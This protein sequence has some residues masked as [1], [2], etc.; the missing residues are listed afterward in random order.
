MFYTLQPF[1]SHTRVT[2]I[3]I[4]APPDWI[5]RLEQQ[6][7]KRQL[8]D[9]VRVVAGGERRQD[10]VSN[11]LQATDSANEI[12]LIHDAGRPFVTP[13]MIAAAITGCEKTDGGTIV[14]VPAT[15]TVKTVPAGTA[16]ISATLP[17]N[18][19]WLAQTPQ[20]FPRAVLLEALAAA[21]RDGICGT[22]EAALVERLGYTVTVVPGAVTNIKITTRAE[23][24]FATILLGEHND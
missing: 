18:E 12:I 9:R 1:L 24:Q 5:T 15:D 2:E 21:L 3:I 19:I 16:K 23:W 20:V 6:I 10:S 14:A 17:R 13:E 7:A 11:G 22:D 8:S 4:A